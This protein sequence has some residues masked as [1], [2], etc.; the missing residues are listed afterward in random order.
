MNRGH[1]GSLPP[2][3]QRRP[4]RY[5]TVAA[6]LRDSGGSASS[7]TTIITAPRRPCAAPER[8]RAADDPWVAAPERPGSSSERPGSSSERPRAAAEWIVPDNWSAATD[9]VIHEIAA[10]NLRGQS[11]SKRLKKMEACYQRHENTAM[12]QGDY[13]SSLARQVRAPAPPVET[14]RTGQSVLHFWASWFK[15]AA[16]PLSQAKKTTP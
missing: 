5:G 8:P 12:G 3:D 7:S 1:S 6:F 9:H 14:F 10:S 15:D 16:A 11:L 2:V 13:E 4:G